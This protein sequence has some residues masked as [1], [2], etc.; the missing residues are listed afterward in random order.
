MLT[1]SSS[2]GKEDYSPVHTKWSIS[3]HIS[4][5]ILQIQ[6]ITPEKKEKIHM[7]WCYQ[8]AFKIS[9]PTSPRCPA[10]LHSINA[11]EGHLFQIVECAGGGS[12]CF[13]SPCFFLMM[14]RERPAVETVQTLENNNG[15]CHKR[16]DGYGSP[17]SQPFGKRLPPPF[18]LNFLDQKL[19][20]RTFIWWRDHTPIKA[21][22]PIGH[23]PLMGIRVMHNVKDIIRA[24]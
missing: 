13:G 17:K 18:V 1:G 21:C 20:D 11:Q 6:V 5:M 19:Q 14:E 12:N 2:H 4:Q 7:I 8:D 15:D 23:P 24:A 9:T 3:T 22:P 10:I 16:K